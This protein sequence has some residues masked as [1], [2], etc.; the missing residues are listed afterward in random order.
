MYFQIKN[1]LK[2]NYN[3]IS[4]HPYESLSMKAKNSFINY[5]GS[6]KKKHKK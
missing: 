6:S 3:N 5:G 1:T 2:N 4:K